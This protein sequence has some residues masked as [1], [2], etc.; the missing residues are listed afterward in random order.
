MRTSSDSLV[1]AFKHKS[2]LGK[3]FNN[4]AQRLGIHVENSAVDTPDQNG[5]AERAGGGDTY[6]GLSYADRTKATSFCIV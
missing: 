2:R 1:S 3:E 4:W 6:Q 5:A